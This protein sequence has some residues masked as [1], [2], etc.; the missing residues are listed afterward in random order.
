MLL[1]QALLDSWLR[2]RQQIF[3][4]ETAAVPIALAALQADVRGRDVVTFCDNE[5]AVSTLIRGAS[6]SEDVTLLAELCH[7]LALQLQVRL[8]VDWIDSHSNPADGLS[9]G[10]LGD[11]WTAQQGYDLLELSS[12]A[13]PQPQLEIFEWSEKMLHWG[14]DYM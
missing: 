5:A 14:Y 12:A 1:P 11:Q 9:R 8:W 4:A 3:R 2:R 13:L 10:G 7:A 6:R